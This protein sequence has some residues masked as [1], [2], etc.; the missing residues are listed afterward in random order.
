MR[1]DMSGGRCRDHG[2]SRPLTVMM[3]YRNPIQNGGLIEGIGSPDKQEK[4][5]QTVLEQAEMLSAGWVA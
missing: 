4:A 3:I 5:T 2:E 1:R